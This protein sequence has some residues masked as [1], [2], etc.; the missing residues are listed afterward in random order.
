M[1]ALRPHTATTDH[2]L[3]T[4]LRRGD[5]RAFTELVGRHRPALVA[6]ATRMLGDRAR[7]EDCVQEALL[8]AHAALHRD[9][10]PIHAGPWLRRIVRHAAFDD[11]RRP[12][13]A[14][15]HLVKVDQVRNDQVPEPAVAVLERERLRAVLDDIARLPE[16]ER[17]VFVAVTIDGREHADV[18]RRLGVS[19]ET[20]RRLLH[21]AA[22]S[23]RT[24]RARRRA[25]SDPL[26]ISR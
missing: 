25:A 3:V 21:R 22:L 26:V 5:E 10:R 6:Q 17:A 11:L 20:T 24:A 4:A 15:S 23:M 7:A 18:A 19:A 14:Q 9:E 16:R 13:L 12:Y 8:R 1:P 2:D